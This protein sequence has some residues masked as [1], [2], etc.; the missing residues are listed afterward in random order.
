MTTIKKPEWSLLKRLLWIFL[1]IASITALYQFGSVWLKFQLLYGPE[2]QLA[3]VKS[4][5][6]KHIAYFSVKYEG[7]Q[8]WWPADPQPHFYITV[9][10]VQSGKVLL[11][12]TDFNRHKIKNYNS[13]SDSFTN[14]ARL[15][16][17][18][19]EFRFQPD[20]PNPMSSTP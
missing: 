8:P 17:P 4:P 19:A 15:Y 11:R 3:Q 18:W 6:G 14:L 12:E 5:D 16:A 13:T 7:P 1:I 20:I 10:D 2:Q 9:T